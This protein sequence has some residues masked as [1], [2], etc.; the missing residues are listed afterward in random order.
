MNASTPGP[1][2]DLTGRHGL[3]PGPEASLVV[4]AFI[5]SSL[6]LDPAVL[7]RALERVRSGR[8]GRLDPAARARLA[9]VLEEKGLLA[10]DEAWDALVDALGGDGGEEDAERDDEPSS[11]R[12]STPDPLEGDAEA[13]LSPTPGPADSLPPTIDAAEAF[14]RVVRDALAGSETPNILQLVNELGGSDGRWVVVPIRFAGDSAFR[15]SMRLW[16]PAGAVTP[17]SLRFGV[18]DLTA[19][20]QRWTFGLIPEA[21]GF[22]VVALEWPED[23]TTDFAS[24]A[25]RLDERDIGFR[26]APLPRGANDG[27]STVA[28]PGILPAVDRL[29]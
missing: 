11:R 2:P 7:G 23:S 9:A 4:R 25:D 1:T 18:V 19:D 12:R 24:L 15:G 3:P 10:S 28:D 21:G 27:F 8:A 5:R 26:V 14:A 22:G 13:G 16:L 6:P 17:G 20:G 29:A